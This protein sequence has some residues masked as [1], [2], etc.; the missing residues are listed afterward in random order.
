NSLPASIVGLSAGEFRVDESGGATYQLPLSLPAG[1]AGVQPQLAFSY[2]SNAG[3]GY[4]GTGWSFAGTSA[5]T[6]CPKNIA[7]DGVQGNVAFANSDRLCLGGQRLLAGSNTDAGYWSAGTYYPEIDDFSI[8]R[9]HGSATQGALGYTVETKSGEI[10]YYGEVSAVSGNDGMAKP[11]AATFKTADGATQ[12]GSDAFFNTQAGENIARMW[13]LKAIRDVKGNYIVFKYAEDLTKGEHY[14]TEVHYT[15]RVNGNA[16]FAKVVLEYSEN[17]KKAQGWQAGVPVAMTKLLNKVHVLVDNEYYRHY[18][19]NYRSSNVIEEKNYLESV[20]EC[21]TNDG[22]GCLPATTFKW[23]HPEFAVS[24]MQPNCSEPGAPCHDDLVT[25]P[26]KPFE[27]TSTTRNFSNER[28]YTQMIDINGDGFVD[29]VY[30]RN[31]AW[32]ARLG[33]LNA[34]WTENCYTIEGFEDCHSTSALSSFSAEVLLSTFGVAN[35]DYLQTIDYDGDGKRDLLLASGENAAWSVILFKP[36]TSTR[37]NCA[38]PT[39][40]NCGSTTITHNTTLVSTGKLAY[41]FKNGATVA[42]V[43][44]DG[45]EDILFIKD[46]RFQ[47]YINLGVNA[48]GEHQGMQHLTDA[49]SFGGNAANDPFSADF[50]TGS[51]DMKSAAMFDVNGDGKTDIVLKVTEGSCSRGAINRGDC[52]EAGGTWTEATVY[53]LYTSDGS[54]YNEQQTLGKIRNVRA[55]DLNG[56]GYTDLIFR[57]EFSNFWS[58]RLSN[59]KQ[60]HNAVQTYFSVTDS[61]VNLTQFVDINADGRTDILF[62][63]TTSRW[64]VELSAPAQSASQVAFTARGYLNYDAGAAVRFTDINADGKLDLLTATSDNGWKIFRSTRPFIKDHVINGI[65]N[66][67]GVKTSISYQSIVDKDVYIR[68]DS[69]NNLN[70]DYFSPLSGMYVVS[71]VSTATTAS[72][73]VGVSYRYAGMLLHKK[74]RGMLGFEELQTIDKQTDVMTRTVYHQLWPFTGIPKHTTQWLGDKLLSSAENTLGYVNI[75]TNA[76]VSG[77]GNAEVASARIFPFVQSSEELSYQLGS[78][79][80]TVYTLAKTNS[81]FAYDKFGNLTSS[82]VVQTNPDEPGFSQTTSTSNI[83]TGASTNYPRYGRLTKTTVNKTLVE[84]SG[85]QSSTRISSFEYYNDLML[86]TETLAPTEPK[87]RVVTTHNYDAAGNSTGQTVTAATKADGTGVQSRSSSTLFDNR[88]RFVKQTTDALGYKTDYTYDSKSADSITGRVDYI[89]QTDANGQ[90]SRAYFNILGQQSRSYSKGAGSSDPVVDQYSA[91]EYCSVVS[92]DVTGAYVRIRSWGDG[93]GEKQQF[94]DMF[95]REIATKAKLLA[96]NSWSTSA[97]TYDAQGRP[98]L[99]YEP[100]TTTPGAYSEAHYDDLGRIKSTT[101]ANGAVSSV[102]HQGL[103]SVTTDALNHTSTT[104]T[105]YAGQTRQV[106]DHLGN[107]LGYFYDAN[108]NLKSVVATDNTGTASERT[109]NEYDAYGRKTSMKDQDKGEWFYTYNAFGELLTQQN[110]EQQVTAFTYDAVG[111]QLRRHDQSGTTCWDYGNSEISYNRGKLV[112]VRSFNSSVS[113]DTTATADYEELYGYNSRGLVAN[114]LVRTAGSSF[115]SSTSYDSY[116]RLY[117]LTYPSWSLS[118]SDDI[119]VRHE[120]SSNNGMLTALKN[121]KN[122]A[123]VYQ[124]VIKVNARGQATEVVYGNGAKETRGFA[125][126]T[127]WVKSLNLYNKTGALAHNFEYDYQLNGNLDWREQ[128]FGLNSSASFKEDFDYDTLDR[129]KKRTIVNIGNSSAYSALPASLKM[130]ENY[131]YDNWGN[132]TS[133]SGVG[134]YCYDSSKTNRLIAVGS[135]TSCAGT[136]A[137]TFGYDNNGNVT[138]DGKRSF[139]YTAFEKPSRIKQGNNYTDFAYGPDRQLYRRT[140]LRD[141]KTTDTLYIDGLYERM[142]KSTGES[143]HKFY[144]GNA[145]ITKRSNSIHSD[146]LYLHKDNQGSTISITN[147]GGNVVQQFIYDP[148]GKQYS[149]S[150]S[151]LFTTYSNPGD[152]KGYTGHKMINDFDVIHMGGRTYNPVLGRFMQADPFIQAPS[153]L[154]NYNRY[155]YVLNNPMSYT[156]PS[157]YIFKKL[158][159][160]FGKLAPFV[161]LLA[162]AI[163]GVGPWAMANWYQAAAFGFMSGGVATGN[164][165]GAIVGAISGA[166]FQ[167]IGSHFK[168]LSNANLAQV[169]RVASDGFGAL[170]GMMGDNLHSFGGL[171]LSAG[172]VAGQIASHAVAGG[173]VSVVSGGKFGHGFISAGITKGAGGA[174]LKGGGNLSSGDIVKGTVLSAVISGTVSELTGGKFANGASTGAFQYLF[175]HARESMLQKSRHWNINRREHLYGTE[176]LVCGNGEPACTEAQAAEALMLYPAPGADGRSPVQDGGFSHIGGFGTVDHR[177]DPDGKGVWNFT[178]SNHMLHNGWVHRRVVSHSGGIYIRT[179]GAGSGN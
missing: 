116:N 69:G 157:G 44:G 81:S 18:Q 121:H 40:V 119:V 114:K 98:K 160:M 61:T 25:T 33:G 127:G 143:E 63:E 152:S 62:P 150:T 151:S 139:T 177:V 58:Y 8:I 85:T 99:S 4:M 41:G 28:F 113:C 166:A 163:P 17:P 64:R 21:V 141:G 123:E 56:D 128:R 1:I 7:I 112:R 55:G 38:R 159:K 107:K 82:T 162:L 173:I 74:G 35:K 52:I 153:N 51:A 72:A 92:C 39:E 115:A 132:I 12:T 32:Y 165:R 31:G 168:S 97:T 36:S 110:A 67:W 130:E 117:T 13:A 138:N 53:K 104:L 86:K 43:N 34:T 84:D 5:I 125:A 134:N 2:N 78:D 45:L 80:A 19:L 22:K 93:Q 65:T 10:H 120:Y 102:S 108:G 71:D 29:M 11:L 91:T 126:D 3:D 88:F 87:Y 178:R 148:W 24:S 145:V 47:A 136:G 37:V 20:Q 26:F 142:T 79:M 49:G 95:G 14:L 66:G 106:T 169:D 147:A 109:T 172:Q 23:S 133:K 135:T 101:A 100:Y 27:A 57:S 146:I 179:Y 103:I 73:S 176:F 16:P 96:D 174:F 158:N 59:G 137:Y 131:A 94:L 124:Q 30:P 167:Q 6:R 149:V 154:Q 155:S 118:P 105:N 46:G 156:D 75:A 48:A 140:D 122:A 76:T 9:S 77:A 70:S 15:G 170:A 90:V 42:D 50:R 83:Y 68:R 161:G 89:T 144:V 171:S 129:L 54:R 60:F 175:N 111:R 164:L